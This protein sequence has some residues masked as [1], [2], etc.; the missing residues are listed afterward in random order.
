MNKVRFLD[1]LSQTGYRPINYLRRTKIIP[2]STPIMTMPEM[3]APIKTARLVPEGPAGML[4]EKKGWVNVGEMGCVSAGVK[5][6]SVLPE[7][8][9]PPKIKGN[10]V[11]VPLGGGGVGDGGVGDGGVGEGGGLGL[12]RNQG[13]A[14]LSLVKKSISMPATLSIPLLEG[15][16]Q[17]WTISTAC[18]VRPSERGRPPSAHR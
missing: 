6:V 1:K 18:Q 16:V 11:W 8:G 9:V 7:V 2:S 5:G 3:A 15:C 13:V 14:V 10:R 4:S 12:A 17:S